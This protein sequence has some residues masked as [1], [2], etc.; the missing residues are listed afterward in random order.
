MNPSRGFGEA[1]LGR[2]PH[3]LL[4][5]LRWALWRFHPTDLRALLSSAGS[6][7]IVNVI[8]TNGAY[9]WVYN[10]TSGSLPIAV[11]LHM[12]LNVAQW[13][14]P[15]G[16]AEGAVTGLVVQGVVVW[17]R[18]PRLTWTVYRLTPPAAAS[19][20]VPDNRIVASESPGLPDAGIPRSSD[21]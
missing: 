18:A 12:A 2:L 17:G 8:A 1:A 21:R 3:S 7:L 20:M 13:V 9:T 4:L 16:L 19:R 15:I 10:H 11:L 14:A 6:S 5:G